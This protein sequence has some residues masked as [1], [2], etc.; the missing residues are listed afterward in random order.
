MGEWPLGEIGNGVA[1]RIWKE[2][3]FPIINSVLLN[4]FYRFFLLRMSFLLCV[5]I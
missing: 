1:S 3:I 2:R 5:F 4:Y